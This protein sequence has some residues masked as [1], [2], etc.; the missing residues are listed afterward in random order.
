MNKELAKTVKHPEHYEKAA[1]RVEKAYEPIE[2]CEQYAFCMGN[3]LKYLL[4]AKHKGNYVE[5]LA[6]AQWYLQREFVE[7][8]NSHEKTIELYKF[9]VSK[10]MINAF[11]QSN[12]FIKD[13]IDDQGTYSCD[14]IRKVV[15]ELETEIDK[16]TDLNNRLVGVQV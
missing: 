3:A 15:D 12:P 1:V 16:H 8:D 7:V 14:S 13:L 9:F 6:K 2:L 10:D 4:R 11:R 5:D